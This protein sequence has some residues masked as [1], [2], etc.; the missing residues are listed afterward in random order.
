M[1]E[2]ILSGTTLLAIVIRNSPIESGIRFYTPDHFPLQLGAMM[3]DK[4]Y[5]IVP[6]VHNKCERS[7][8]LTQEVLI[9]KTGSVKVDF[10]TPLKAY[11]CSVVLNAGD[12]VFLSEGGHGF[13]FLEPSE[14]IEVKQGPYLGEL[15]KTRFS[16]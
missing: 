7:S 16:P 9:I 13:E 10:Y 15:D 6:H 5:T 1:I 14:V 2:N 4:G 8:D 11:E 12:I 3:R